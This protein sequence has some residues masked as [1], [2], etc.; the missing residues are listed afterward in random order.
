MWH[1]RLH[2]FTIM[3]IISI[4]L[5]TKERPR[6]PQFSDVSARY[7]YATPGTGCFEIVQTW[8]DTIPNFL[9]SRLLDKFASPTQRSSGAW[10]HGIGGLHQAVGVVPWMASSVTAFLNI[11]MLKDVS[12]VIR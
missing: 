5:W 6:K 4:Y 7:G 1:M 3:A 9:S 11:R 8:L 10:I 2:I 12:I